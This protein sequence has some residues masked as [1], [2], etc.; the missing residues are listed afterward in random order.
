VCD[1]LHEETFW[2]RSLVTTAGGEWAQ[3]HGLRAHAVKTRLVG[4]TLQRPRNLGVSSPR[5]ILTQLRI[6][7]GQLGRC[8]SP[9][10]MHLA[11]EEV[12]LSAA[13]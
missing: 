12:V 1:F 9:R 8:P 4:N 11:H 2:K 3:R 7:L 5:K 6:Q 13:V 10:P